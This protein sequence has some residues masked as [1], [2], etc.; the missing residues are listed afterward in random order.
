VKGVY[1]SPTALRAIR[2]E[3][4]GGEWVRKY[5]T[6]SLRGVS[7]AGER[8]DIH[9]YEWIRSKLNVLI[10]DCYGQTEVGWLISTNY[11]RLHTFP[12]KP[13]STTKPVPGFVV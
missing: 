9:T 1:T 5:D 8:C 2:K 4:E 6:S 13:G 10:S 7:V 12:S 3:D 11:H